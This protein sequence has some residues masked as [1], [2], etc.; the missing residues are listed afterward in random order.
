LSLK[1]F[2]VETVE[3]KNINF[4]VWDVGGQE[5][6]ARSGATTSRTHR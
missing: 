1:G 5:R 4:T 3:Y 2:N 6:F